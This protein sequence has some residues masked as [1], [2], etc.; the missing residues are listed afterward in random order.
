MKGIDCGRGDRAFDLVGEF[1]EVA[2][3]QRGLRHVHGHHVPY[4]LPH[5]QRVEQREARGVL[6]DQGRESIQDIQTISR[7][8]PAPGAFPERAAPTGDCRVDIRRVARGD[9]AQWFA[10]GGIDDGELSGPGRD[11][12]AVNEVTGRIAQFGGQAVP[13]GAAL[14]NGH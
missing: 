12:L 7:S 4:G 11:V 1:R 6:L 3:R 14:R 2:E 9:L 10:R 8:H 13:L 5:A